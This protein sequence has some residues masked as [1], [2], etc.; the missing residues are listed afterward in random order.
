MNF[1]GEINVGM[2]IKLDQNVTTKA[3]STSDDQLMV[4]YSQ[5]PTITQPNTENPN[6]QPKG[7][8]GK[9]LAPDIGI[10]TSSRLFPPRT[11][12]EGTVKNRDCCWYVQCHP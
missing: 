12:Y 6:S 1:N 4:A 3:I 2:W 5:T 9:T 11:A 8:N 10:P 7:P